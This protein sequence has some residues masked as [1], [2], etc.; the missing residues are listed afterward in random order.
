MT[1]RAPQE[2]VREIFKD[3]GLTTVKVC[4]LA[5]CLDIIGHHRTPDI[6]Y[7]RCPSGSGVLRREARWTRL[8][9]AWDVSSEAPA[10][11][12]RQDMPWHDLDFLRRHNM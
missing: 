10:F 12:H 4:T 11:W 9:M 3:M 6:G 7:P 2:S 5:G 1:P 8:R